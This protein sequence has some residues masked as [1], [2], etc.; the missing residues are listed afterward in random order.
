MIGLLAGLF[1]EIPRAQTPK[2]MV[3]M[4]MVFLRKVPG[5][6]PLT[7]NLDAV[8]QRRQ[9]DGMR[10]LLD[11]GKAI[12]GGPIED[13]SYAGLVLLNAKDSSQA[14]EWMKDDPYVKSGLLSVDVLPWLFQNVFKKAPDLLDIEKI[15]FG[16]L[17]RPKNAPQYPAAKLEILQSGHLA[18]IAK[19]AN[20]GILAS[21]G[22]FLT[23]ENR[24]GIFIF[25]SKDINQISRAVA[26]DPLIQ[27]KRLELKIM[28]WWTGKGTVVQY[29]SK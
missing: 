18:N 22:P 19:M 12:M 13:E 24:R 17:E 26:K 4:Q 21:A 14:K 16:I 25:F 6:N 3:T 28:P 10:K 1:T 8:Y 11:E 27:S 2:N 29:K 20:D 15:W 9:L 5:R 23:D 7:K